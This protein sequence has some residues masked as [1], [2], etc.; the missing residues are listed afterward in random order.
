MRYFVWLWMV[1][2][3]L[4]A[5]AQDLDVL[6][7]QFTIDLNDANDTLAGLA[8]IRFINR[9]G[10]TEPHFDLAGVN[11]EGRGMRVSK[12]TNGGN[13]G[14][15]YPFRQESDRV[16]IQLPS[17]SRG[18]T[19]SVFIVYK[20]IPDD[21]L[22]I[23][24]N[25]YG[26]RTF[27]ADNWPNRAHH[28]IPCYD[29][30]DDKASFGFTVTAPKHYGVISNGI[31]V[32]EVLLD[33]GRKRTSW[34][35][36]IALP[37]KVMVIGVARF[38]VKEFAD[39][40]AGIPVSAWVYPQDSTRGFYDYAL[41]PGIVRFFSN[42]IAPYP[43]K[44]LANVQS[45]TIFGGMENASCIF[46]A[47]ESVTGTRSSEDLLAHE[48]AHQW[49]GDMASEKSFPH[50]W[51]SEG[52]AT[53][54]TDLYL[55]RKYGKDAFAKRMQKERSTV[56]GFRPGATTPVVDSTRAFMELLNPN[57]YQKGA[58]VLHMLRHEVGDSTFHTILQT[59]YQQYEGGNAD[60]RDFQRIAEKVSGRE[61]GWFFNQWLYRP[62]VPR[63]AVKWK[64]DGDKVKVEVKQT[65][66]TVYR[67]PLEIGVV[68]AEGKQLFQTITVEGK[69]TEAKIEKFPKIVKVVLDP[70]T[71]LLFEGVVVKGK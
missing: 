16:Y 60:T 29:L 14:T 21:G 6:H 47:E 48:I 7:Y 68:T 70:N 42:Y 9:D 12:V 53:Y 20:G 39:R 66:S 25:K 52:F 43:Y 59:Y 40:P 36:E 28:W 67:F 31:K 17:A 26:D 44:K 35:E 63:L 18:D 65:G 2:F 46:Y 19:Q 24:K 56:L 41:A 10:N 57:S 34:R 37:T 51:L 64:I 49:F 33:K 1:L 11:S 8:A 13:T 30:P 55:E 50:L 71:K 5:G 23:S 58:W 38:A 27:F 4:C 15:S 22:I 32:E 45:K 54:M 62:G 61:L 3:T 69:E